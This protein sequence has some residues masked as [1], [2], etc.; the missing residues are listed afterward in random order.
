MYM[1]TCSPCLPDFKGLRVVLDY[2]SC[3]NVSIQRIGIMLSYMYVV[4][5]V[6]FCSFLLSSRDYA[7]SFNLQS[8]EFLSTAVADDEDQDQATVSWTS[9]YM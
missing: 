8:Y 2:I 7:S 5:S 9:T 6:Y 4:K 1:Y 3:F